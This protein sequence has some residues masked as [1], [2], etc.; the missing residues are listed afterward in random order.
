MISS[1]RCHIEQNLD[2]IT[3]IERMHTLHAMSMNTFM[4]NILLEMIVREH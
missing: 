4:T 3:K 1:N 2:Y